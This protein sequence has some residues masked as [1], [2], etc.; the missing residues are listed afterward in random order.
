MLSRRI[1][2]TRSTQKTACALHSPREIAC[3][4]HHLYPM[5]NMCLLHTVCPATS[6]R[7]NLSTVNAADACA[8]DLVKIPVTSS[9]P[10]TVLPRV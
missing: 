1:Q 9:S 8:H 3:S 5:N 10:I 7:Y 2:S 4:L 6:G